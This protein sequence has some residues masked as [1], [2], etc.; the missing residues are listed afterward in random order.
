MNKLDQMRASDNNEDATDD[1]DLAYEK[2]EQSKSLD[3]F[4]EDYFTHYSDI[5]ISIK[6]DW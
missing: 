5:K 1:Y 4:K 3:K 2:R 6:E